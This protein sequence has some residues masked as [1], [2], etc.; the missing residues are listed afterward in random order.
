MERLVRFCYRLTGGYYVRP[1][2]R[3]IWIGHV[4]KVPNGSWEGYYKSKSIGSY[5]TRDAAGVA[6]RRKW[7]DDTVRNQY[8]GITETVTSL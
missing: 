4:L 5:S 3:D 8:A 1:I 2:T 6:V 7:L